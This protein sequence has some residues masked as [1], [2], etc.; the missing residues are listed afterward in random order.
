MLKNHVN[1]GTD[2]WHEIISALTYDEKG[3]MCSKSNI[4]SIDLICES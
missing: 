1:A 2:G 4:N 3:V